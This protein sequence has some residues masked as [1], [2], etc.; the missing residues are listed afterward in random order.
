[1]N[2]GLYVHVPFCRS[3]CPY[4]GFYSIPSRIPVE[5]WLKGLEREILQTRNL[6]DSFDT[7]Y[8]GGGTPSFLNTEALERVMALIS[9]H[10]RFA[11]HAE[12]TLEANP[13]DLS[14]E[15]AFLYKTLGFNRINLGVQS[16]NDR[17]LKFLGRR[18]TSKEAERAIGHLRSVDFANMGLDLI[19]GIEGQSMKEWIEGLKKTL[20]FQPEHISCYQ[21]SLEKNTVFERRVQAKEMT[22]L[23]EKKAAA[24]FLATSAFLENAGYLHYEVSNFARNEDLEARH[25][26]KYWEHTPY[27]GLG[28][29]AHSFDGRKRW[30]NVRS[31]KKYCGALQ[32]GLS[33]VEGWEV[34]T[35]EQRHL[36]SLALGFRTHRG[37]PLGILDAASQ[38]ALLKV[39]KMGLLRI[40]EGHAVPTR[41]GYLLADHLP[42]Y[43]A[44]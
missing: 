37:V 6:F 40:I 1:M 20:A 18:H 33:P 22:I 8:L 7:L 34:L 12:M 21:L 30:W 36:E 14:L 11:P 17:V 13:G 24:H 38:K 41:R 42:L 19:C 15:K 43:F 26:R 9:D 27:L 29:S 5:R 4:C 2:P 16:F 32:K 10:Y 31:V 28:P 23:S 39:Q 3:K 35:R 44:P 25:N